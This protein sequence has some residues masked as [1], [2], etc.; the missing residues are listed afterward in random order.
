MRAT[1]HAT[2]LWSQVSSC[3]CKYLQIIEN[4]Q[5]GTPCTWYMSFPITKLTRQ[6]DNEHLSNSSYVPWEYGAFSLFPLFSMPL[7]FFIRR[8]L[9]RCHY[10]N[11]ASFHHDLAWL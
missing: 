11:A 10:G 3:H 8:M 1:P 9:H 7:S 5:R 2:Q 4:R 6:A